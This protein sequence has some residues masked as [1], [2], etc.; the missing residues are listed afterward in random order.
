MHGVP[1]NL[2]FEPFRGATLTQLALG[3]FQLQFHFS[4]PQLGIY[5]EGDW[6]IRNSAGEIIDR[7]LPNNQRDSFRAHR[8]LGRSI[9]R[10]E[11]DPPQSFT[12]HFDNGWSLSVF[13]SSKQYESF[14]IQ[15]GDIYV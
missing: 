4:S 13:D 15:P 7:S 11:V 12:L 3:E 10:S 9:V 2:T 5:I 6:E 8:L 1:N 14:S